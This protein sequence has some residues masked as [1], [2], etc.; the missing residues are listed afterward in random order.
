MQEELKERVK[1]WLKASHLDRQWLADRC[2]V[3]IKTVNNWLS[4]PRPIP[5]KAVLII[6]A[7]MDATVDPAPPESESVIVLR[8]DE[9][10]FDAYNRASMAEGLTIRDWAINALD[11]AAEEDTQPIYHALP[12]IPGLKVA[13]DPTGSSDT[14]DP[15]Q[16]EQ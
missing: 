10:R 7:I 9:D 4:S 15:V 2:G 14:S 11:Q 8:V 6:R 5:A 16:S 3:E 1:I 13:T 12:P